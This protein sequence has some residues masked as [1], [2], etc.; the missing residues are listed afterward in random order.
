[1]RARSKF[2]Q[3]ET[4]HILA[5]CIQEPLVPDWYRLKWYGVL[6]IGIGFSAGGIAMALSGE[7]RGWIVF[8]F[9]LF[10]AAMAVHELWPKVIERHQPDNPDMVLGRYPGPVIL[11]VPRSKQ[12]FFLVSGLV[13]GGCLVYVALYGDLSLAANTFLW[14][15]VLLVAAASP[16]MLLAILRGSTLRLDADGLR[17]FQGLKSTTLRW[18][19]VSEFSV[20]DAGMLSPAQHLM[21]VFDEDSTKAGTIAGFNRGLLGR[22]GG[23]P[24]TYG[25]D[26][27]QLAW[28]LNEWRG[29]ALASP[30]PPSQSSPKP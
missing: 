19:N 30:Q 9:F 21:V 16:V 15:S 26:S 18:R 28:L 5:L 23:L 14:L 29:R 3:G 2:P 13:F 6:A 17:I 8:L 12:I 22:S 24:D 20:A 7:G 1:L 25:M 4:A 27:W 11:R 10:C